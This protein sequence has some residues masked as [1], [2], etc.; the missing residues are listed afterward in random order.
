MNRA[1]LSANNRLNSLTLLRDFVKQVVYDLTPEGLPL[2]SL[3]QLLIYHLSCF[4]NKEYI[5]VEL[6]S[7]GWDGYMDYESGETYLHTDSVFGYP[8][9][10][11]H[12]MKVL[13][14]D[15]SN[16]RITDNVTP[17][18]F[19]CKT[20]YFEAAKFFI[21]HGY[22]DLGPY[23][24]TDIMVDLLL[25]SKFYKIR[26]FICFLLNTG[27]TVSDFNPPPIAVILCRILNEVKWYFDDSV[28]LL[29]DFGFEPNIWN[30]VFVF[31]QLRKKCFIIE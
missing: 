23:N 14:I 4:Q 13:P 3:A 17:F 5:F 9:V 7:M 15:T 28:Q 25:A 27:I 26:D 22:V 31:E 2:L 1:S 8:E 10:M 29:Q 30:S 12:A 11:A 16:K 19:A 21:L 24:C 20:G 6:A 18:M